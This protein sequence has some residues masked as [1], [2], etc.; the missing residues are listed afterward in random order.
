MF[1]RTGK[2]YL[3]VDD[4]ITHLEV[5]SEIQVNKKT[6][7]IYR[8]SYIR[9]DGKKRSPAK[10]V[11]TAFVDNPNQ[12]SKIKRIS[13]NILNNSYDN[14]VWVNTDKDYSQRIITAEDLKNI[15][16]S[17]L[18][19]YNKILYEFVVNGNEEFLYKFIYTGG[20]RR[21]LYKSYYDRGLPD[22]RFDLFLDQGYDVLKKRL[23][24]Y[25]NFKINTDN[26]ARKY[27]YLTMYFSAL[28]LNIKEPLIKLDFLPRELK[29]RYQDYEDNFLEDLFEN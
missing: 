22:S 29:N 15:D 23:K 9:F 8:S 19:D 2:F 16:Y 14:L 27:I 5:K 13:P 11:A 17:L 1:F 6:F 4:L 7:K 12:F 24:K 28:A 20:F 21:Y 25:Y 26:Q 3:I 10:L 18:C